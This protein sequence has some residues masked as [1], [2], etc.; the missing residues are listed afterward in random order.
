M[1]D[2]LLDDI[3]DDDNN[4]EI[5]IEIEEEAE[6][7][8]EESVEVE[9]DNVEDEDEEQHE[10]EV[11]EKTE[12]ESEDAQMSKRV[13]RR[14]NKLT[15]QRKS[16]EFKLNGTI[17]EN[18]KYQQNITA[19]RRDA[20]ASREMVLTEME[21]RLDLQEKLATIQKTTAR[22]V[23]DIEEE[24]AADSQL[25]S[26]NHGKAEL[27]RYKAAQ[28]RAM[29]KEGIKVEK[30]EDGERSFVFEDSEDEGTAPPPSRNERQEPQVPAEVTAWQKRNKWFLDS[31]DSV[32]KRMTEA[33]LSI[34]NE[35]INE[36]GYDVEGDVDGYLKELDTQMRELFP[37]KF[38]KKTANSSAARGG[39]RT[40]G[41]GKT[42][43]MRR[44]GGKIKVVLTDTQLALI[45]LGNITKEEYIK[46]LPEYKELARKGR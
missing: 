27:K 21:N 14:I 11:Q 34:S 41:G 29:T 19:A 18:R 38:K 3:E 17:E 40:S 42:P 16:A 35:L 44:S 37:D 25:A 5:E 30:D 1:A 39:A 13:Q 12:E 24:Q 45:E 23:G 9:E 15:A 43:G 32:N 2:E 36:E 6:A 33:A 20:V 31:K 22:Q 7:D 28:K 46:Q 8:G 10:E 4:K 26:V